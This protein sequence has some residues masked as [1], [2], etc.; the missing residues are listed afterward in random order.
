MNDCQKARD[1]F[2]L[3]LENE[4][5]QFEQRQIDGHL[6]ACDD[7][8]REWLEF[9]ES[10]L[11]LA[12]LPR[13]AVSA[14]FEDRVMA[15]MREAVREA[16][17]AP[18]WR[19]VEAEPAW[20]QGWFPRLGMAG[21]AAALVAFFSFQQMQSRPDGT[22]ASLTTGT[23]LTAQVEPVVDRLQDRFPDLPAEVLRSLD[24]ESYVLDRMTVHPGV[25]GG[26][27]VV[28]PVS[29]NAGGPV[30]ITF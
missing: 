14:S 9:K 26:Q 24:E 29:D 3:A 15:A 21:A 12:A 10:Q 28:A 1:L 8:R 4:A 20:W 16:R 2:S 19:P 23:A 18:E 17:P 27:R 6:S 13:V 22:T 7:C 30:F 25:S 11:M 5:S